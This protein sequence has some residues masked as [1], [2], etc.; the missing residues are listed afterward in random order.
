[1]SSR[2][3]EGQK[4]RIP[5]LKAS[6]HAACSAWNTKDNILKG[7]LKVLPSTTTEGQS[8]RHFKRLLPREEPS[9][10][11]GIRNSLSLSKAH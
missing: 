5:S 2:G 3:G 10:Y 7:G 9:S 4:Q 6:G 8:Y 1:M 11:K